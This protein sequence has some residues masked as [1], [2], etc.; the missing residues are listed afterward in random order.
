MTLVSKFPYPVFRR[1]FDP[2]AGGRIYEVDGQRLPSVT[3]ILSRTKDRSG[4]QRWRRRV[5]DEEAD[6]IVQESADLGTAMHAW[7]E[8]WVH[9][10]PQTKPTND[11]ERLAHRMAQV[12]HDRALV[13]IE[14]IWGNEVNL[15]YPG[16]Y[17]G[18]ADMVAV[19]GGKPC[20]IDFKS[21]RSPR[22]DSYNFDYYCQ[23]AAYAIAHNALFGTSIERGVI[24][25]VSRD[26]IFQQF[27]IEGDRFHEMATAWW[28][29]LCAWLR[30][31]GMIDDHEVPSARRASVERIVRM[32]VEQD[33]AS[34]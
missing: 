27:V 11:I 32:V 29:R 14:E 15:Y 1:G 10:R 9:G 19:Y 5:G 8:N 30:M 24:F 20:I 3:T 6:R 22:K 18:T 28:D 23:L 12:M 21:T 2:A 31:N 25:A 13:H 33:G 34:G 26:G 17:A 16:L 7:I 4:L